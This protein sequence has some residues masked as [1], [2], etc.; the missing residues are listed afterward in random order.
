VKR[1]ALLTL[2]LLAI[3][4]ACGHTASAPAATV[5]GNR[6]STQEL[7]DELN[8]ISA[9]P[10]YITSLQS[11]APSNGLTVL[12]ST[13]GSFDAAFVSQ[14]LLR[15]MDYSLIRAEVANRH[16]SIND[17]CKLQARNDALQNLGQ[18]DA[19]AGQAL[20]EKFPKR[21][22]DLLVQRNTDVLALEAALNGQTCGNSADAQSYY[23]AHHDQFT[24][25]C[26]SLIAVTDPAQADSIVA[27]ARGGA[28]FAALVRQFSVDSTSKAQDGALGC[29][30]SS[31]FNPTIAGLLNAAKTGDV[32]D[33]I[34]GQ[35][36]L[37]IV[38]LTDRQL[39]PFDEVRDQV[40]QM[41]ES[42]AGQAF[43][44]W[45]QGARSNARIDV[46]T[47]YGTFDPAKFQIDPPPIDQS[48]GSS[49]SASSSSQNP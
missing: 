1:V 5:N 39:A 13:P 14:V 46:D 42:A 30:L 33:P 19:T 23:D 2:S 49:S 18:R 45:L 21:Y 26:I 24:K 44:T 9:N 32:L 28:D 16:V 47:R 34:P 20:F 43:G 41:V 29:R 38:K 8:A 37:S 31:A 27:Q 11:G 25:L 6:T 17:A 40:Q 3:A 10:D 12:G 15:Q 48:N 35:N 36:G 22:Q 4:S 7:V